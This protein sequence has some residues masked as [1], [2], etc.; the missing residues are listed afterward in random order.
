MVA[1]IARIKSAFKFF[2]NAILIFYC[3]FQEFELCH[4]LKLSVACLYIMILCYLVT[5]NKHIPRFVC[6]YFYTN[7]LL[8]LL[9]S[10]SWCIYILS[11]I[12]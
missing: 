8:E 2:I 9:C 1:N 7:L 3:R 10:P 12:N 4:I 11:P 6:A 5:S